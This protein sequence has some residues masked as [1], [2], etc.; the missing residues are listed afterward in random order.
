MGKKALLHHGSCTR[1]PASA[2]T[3]VSTSLSTSAP[4]ADK[5]CPGGT[6]CN[7]EPP[8]P[9]RQGVAGFELDAQPQVGGVRTVLDCALSCIGHSRCA[10]VCL[11]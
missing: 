10:G 7:F 3:S 11:R 2:P 4:A 5:V 8:I 9:N 1:T 6:T